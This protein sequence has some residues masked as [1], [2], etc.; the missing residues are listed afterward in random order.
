MIASQTLDLSIYNKNISEITFFFLFQWAGIAG[1]YD[2]TACD[3]ACEQV[4]ATAKETAEPAWA[5]VPHVPDV[6]P[7]QTLYMQ[8]PPSDVQ[9]MLPKSW[10]YRGFNSSDQVEADV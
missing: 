10:L 4:E 2:F 1:F 8:N 5:L 6:K 7:I 3:V 9:A